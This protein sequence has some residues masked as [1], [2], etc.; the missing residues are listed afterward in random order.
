MDTELDQAS[1]SRIMEIGM[2][3]WASKTLLAAVN[4]ELFTHLAG[5]EMT[6]TDIQAKLGLHERGL[7][8]FLDTLTALGFLERNGLKQTAIYRNSNDAEIFLDKNKPDYI[9]GMLKMANDRL[10][11]FWANLEEGL[12]TGLPQNE[13]KEGGRPLFEELYANPEKLQGFLYAMSG[14]QKGNF[15]V[16]STSFDFSKYNTLCDLGGSGGYLSAQV[17]LKNPHMTCTSFDL[18]PVAP[19]AKENIDQLGLA[20]RVKIVSGD[21]F[22]DEIPKADVITM[23][24]I[25]HDWGTK[26]KKRLIKKAYE[27]LPAGGSLVVIENII[28]DDRVENVF[29]LMMSLN[30]LISTPEGYDFSMSDFK[31]WIAEAGFKDSYKI[32]L[33]GSSSAV[34]AV[35]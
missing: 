31:I 9:G 25:L 1:P 16:F 22:N 24:N 23:G 35:K 13:I 17:A 14:L 27:V 30:M 4:M 20:G 33:T 7:Y 15:V 8:D 10:Y 3:F 28:D 6:G 26:E 29:G 12:K 32:Q 18:P 21:F 5:K 11:P 19:I 2:G 34:I